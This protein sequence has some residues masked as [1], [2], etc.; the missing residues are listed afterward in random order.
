MTLPSCCIK[1][2]RWCWSSLYFAGPPAAH[3]AFSWNLPV[4][5]AGPWRFCWDRNSFFCETG[6]DVVWFVGIGLTTKSSAYVT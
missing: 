4:V 5:V 3:H 1:F 2:H 6:K